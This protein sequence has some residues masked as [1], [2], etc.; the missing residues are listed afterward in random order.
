MATIKPDTRLKDKLIKKERDRLGER[1]ADKQ[2]M[3][4]L[5]ARIP[6]VDQAVIPIAVSTLMDAADQ[7]MASQPLL[8]PKGRRSKTSI[9]EARAGL[10]ALHKHL[11]KAEEQLSNLPLDA[12]DAIGQ[13][14]DA[15]PDKLKCPSM[16]DVDSDSDW[17]FHVAVGKIGHDIKQARETVKKAQDQLAKRPHKVADSARNVLAYQVAFVFSNILKVNPSSTKAS[18]LKEN[19]SRGGAAYDRVLRATLKVAGV[20]NYDSGPLIAT[21]LRLHEDP[22]LPSQV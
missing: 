4:N 22:A 17:N 21:G 7:Y 11:V 15:P 12:I 6:Q 20:T 3:R 19:K 9:A 18:Q 2:S 1:A 13:A 5:L 8:D 14:T 16:S 10:T